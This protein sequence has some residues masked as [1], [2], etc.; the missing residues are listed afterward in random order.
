LT[1]SNLYL[2]DISGFVHAGA[3]NKHAYLEQVVDNKG[4]WSTQITPGGG[5]S[6]VMNVLATIVGN[7]DIIACCD[8]NPIIKKEMIPGYKSNREHKHE[9]E[10]SK[11]FT[12]YV[13]EQC[14]ILCGA[15]DGYEA[16]DVIYTYWKELHELYDHIYVY[17]MDSDMYFLVDEKTEIMPISSR[18]KHVTLENFAQTKIHGCFYPYNT[19]TLDKVMNGDTADCIPPL[20]EGVISIAREIFI[21]NKD[22]YGKF[23]DKDMMLAFASGYP[24]ITQ[25]INNVFPLTCDA[26]SM[27]ITEPNAQMVCNWGDAI[28][29]KIYRGRKSPN[30]NVENE[31]AKVQE[32]GMYLE[33]EL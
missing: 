5:L 32:M 24:T 16:D 23:G 9:I 20:P 1:H 33:M 8:R 15:C 6:L 17:T 19:I 3:V 25:Q 2:L 10:V 13:L 26:L 21:E 31:T 30:F 11:Q 29:N 12:E 18:S 27:D 28:K 7:G 4:I 22:M 14:G